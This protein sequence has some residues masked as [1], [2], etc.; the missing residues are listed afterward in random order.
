VKKRKAAHDEEDDDGE[1]EKVGHEEEEEDASSLTPPQPFSSSACAVTRAP[2]MVEW[3]KQ[4]VLKLRLQADMLQ[5]QCTLRS[6]KDVLKDEQRMTKDAGKRSKEKTHEAH[7]AMK[8]EFVTLAKQCAK[9]KHRECGR[10]WGG[11]RGQRQRGQEPQGGDDD[12]K[13]W[14]NGD[15]EEEW[16]QKS[17]H[18]H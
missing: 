10:G 11:Q 15:N 6:F 7:Q 5:L 8:L 4:R 18:A 9:Q 3:E 16:R 2:L 13:E 17:I 14:G 1:E 12:E